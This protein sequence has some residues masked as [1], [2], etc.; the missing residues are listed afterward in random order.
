MDSFL[1][2]SM[3]FVPAYRRKFIDSALKTNA[4]AL[5]IDLEDAVPFEYKADARVILKE[6]ILNGAFRDKK[7]FVRLNAIESKMLFEDI[8]VVLYEDIAGVMLTKVYSEEDMIYYDKLFAQFE[9]EK[10]LEVG[11]FKFLPLIETTAAVLN[12]YSIA[13]ASKRTIAVCFGGED[14]LNDLEGLHKEP[15]RTFDYPR[16]TIAIAARAAG[17]LPIDTPYLALDNQEGFIKEEKISFEM[18]FAGALLI[19]PKQIELAHE[20]FMPEEDE[21]TRSIEI[22]KAIQEAEKTGSG[23]AMLNGKMI[24]PPMRKRA[25]KVLHIVELAKKCDDKHV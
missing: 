12:V 2:R 21:I 16:A 24:G 11:H 9:Q 23:V 17:V 8:E 20:C 4:D 1:L 25:Q 15:P 10:G 14:F 7:V 18:G 5:I 3:L 19:H 22:G 6:Y 13:K